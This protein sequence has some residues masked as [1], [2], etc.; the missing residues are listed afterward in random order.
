MRFGQ[1]SE[2]RVGRAT[3]VGWQAGCVAEREA[4]NS[5]AAK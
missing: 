2:T 4:L 5:D 1:A 3:R